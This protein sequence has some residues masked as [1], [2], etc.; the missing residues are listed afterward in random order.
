MTEFNIDTTANDIVKVFGRHAAGKTF[1]V[2]GPSAGGLGATAAIALAS[3]SPK[4]I[5]L[6]GRTQS[7][8]L[9]TI[10]EISK[11]SNGK[12]IATF[13]EVDLSSLASVRAAVPKI[14]EAAPDGID[15]LLNN[16]G[17]MAPREFKKSVDGVEEQFAANHL[18]HFL[19]TN[20]LIS[21]I[22][23]VKG[24][25]ANV[26][27]RAW[28]LTDPNYD[29]VNFGDGKTYNGWI[30]YARSK[31]ANIHFSVA[32]AKRVKKLGIAVFA[33]DPGMAL[34]SNLIKT[35]GVDDAWFAEGFRIASE[36]NN[37]VP[38]TQPVISLQQGA[39]SGT[40]A[41]LNPA[42]RESSGSYIEE[43]QIADDKI[44]SYAKDPVI[45]EKLWEVSEKLIGEKFTI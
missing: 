13:V 5:I 29:D 23:K 14:R 37:G 30:G 45:S 35:S 41:L 6:A 18:G 26:T 24:V 22:A 25:V 2:T 39:A 20:L 9:P 28:A 36:R 21:D 34:E 3:A 12:T 40:L 42:L 43:S 33:V 17:I 15:S 16:A 31:I 4:R 8:A 27:S 44:A 11:A 32:L 38:P 7:K 10:D 1:V 19:L